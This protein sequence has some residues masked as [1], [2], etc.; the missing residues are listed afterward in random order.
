MRKDRQRPTTPN[1]SLIQAEVV[2]RSGS[3]DHDSCRPSSQPRRR[4]AHGRRT[5][6]KE[7]SVGRWRSTQP[8]AEELWARAPCPFCALRRCGDAHCVRCPPRAARA[9]RTRGAMTAPPP[10]SGVI[11]LLFAVDAADAPP[12]CGG[13]AAALPPS[14][15][16][17]SLV[18]G[19]D[20][21]PGAADD[22]AA[23]P[24]DAAHVSSSSGGGGD[25]R[26]L[27]T[28]ES[29]AS[30]LCLMGAK[31]RHST[32]VAARVFDALST[33][34]RRAQ[35][36]AGGGARALPQRLPRPVV[37]TATFAGAAASLP[38][39]Q[40]EALVAWALAEYQY[41]KPDQLEDLR[42]ACRRV[43]CL[44]MGVASPGCLTLPC[45]RRIHERRTAVFV[46][47]CGTSGTGKS[48]LAAL[49]V[50]PPTGRCLSSARSLDKMAPLVALPLAVSRRRGWASPPSYPRTPCAAWCALGV[51]R[52][53]CAPHGCSRATCAPD[54]RHCVGERL[55]APLCIHLPGG[56]LSDVRWRAG[57]GACHRGAEAHRRVLCCRAESSQLAPCD[58]CRQRAR[59]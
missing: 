20:A 8:R 49:L 30:V 22:R 17:P 18:D 57:R 51:A 39:P 40:F 28:R 1:L 41:A 43:A 31:P 36:D 54:A 27:Y 12:A 15:P 2:G 6:R 3:T 26:T 29:L 34:C 58:Y 23:A 44:W 7:P 56:R 46:L 5:S 48:T 21:P 16:P 38:R 9:A 59:G 55:P 24:P 45:A 47:L 33:L 11:S 25:R 50:R 14:P 32:K 19:C 13:D 53:C 37:R 42:L 52:P 35:L 4:P 10:G